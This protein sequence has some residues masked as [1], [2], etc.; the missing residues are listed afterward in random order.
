M[1]NIYNDE[2]ELMELMFNELS[3]IR[4]IILY[5]TE[6]DRKTQA[7]LIAFNVKNLFF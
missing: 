4:N 1:L 6:Y 3:G 2:S 5:K 7:P